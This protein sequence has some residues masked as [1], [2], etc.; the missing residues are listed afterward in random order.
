MLGN[1]DV[2]V[3]ILA[4]KLG[5]CHELTSGT[6]LKHY[7]IRLISWRYRLGPVESSA[8]LESRTPP[9]AN[10]NWRRVPNSSRNTHISATGKRHLAEGGSGMIGHGWNTA[11][12]RTADF[13]IL[14]FDRCRAPSA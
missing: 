3:A 2:T 1:V 7:I 11:Q 6:T 4:E 5:Q 13:P 12:T 8:L 9:P 10:W 14:A